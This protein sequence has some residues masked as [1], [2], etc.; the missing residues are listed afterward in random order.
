MFEFLEDF[1]HDLVCAGGLGLFYFLSA[2]VFLT[3][4]NGL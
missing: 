1:F 4:R 3:V 2:M